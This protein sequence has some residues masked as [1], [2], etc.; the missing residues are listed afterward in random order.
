MLL[1]ILICRRSLSKHHCRIDLSK[2]IL[3]TEQLGPKWDSPQVSQ[4]TNLLNRSRRNGA[5]YLS[6]TIPI[7]SPV[8]RVPILQ[9]IASFIGFKVSARWALLSFFSDAINS[10][11]RGEKWRIEGWYSNDK[12]NYIWAIWK[13][14]VAQSGEKRIFE[15]PWKLRFTKI[16]T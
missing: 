13:R 14:C 11:Y 8:N 12:L 7:S 5:F 4:E 3:S 15:L 1:V 9:R 6:F 10:S 2:I 16:V